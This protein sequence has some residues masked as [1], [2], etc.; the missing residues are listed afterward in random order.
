MKKGSLLLMLACLLLAACSNKPINIFDTTA[1]NCNLLYGF[2][3]AG[4]QQQLANPSVKLVNEKTMA[5]A[6]M[7]RK[8]VVEQ[9][10][11]ML[12]QNFEKVKAL[13][14]G[15]DAQ[16]MTAASIALYEYTLPVYKNEYMQLAALYDQNAAAEKITAFEQN[17]A[18]KYAAKFNE[19]YNTII[20]TGTAYAEKH[21][22]P[23][24]QIS[25]SPN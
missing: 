14:A 24:K 8:E 1:L 19:L 5:T 11:T 20:K 7:T 4:M 23:V 3:G 25:T 16:E 9:K 22:I 17:I 15:G 21:G 10:L 6:P 2:A 12:Q 13:N 18:D